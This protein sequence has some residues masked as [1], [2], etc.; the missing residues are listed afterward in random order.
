MKHCIYCTKADLFVC[1][2]YLYYSSTLLFSIQQGTYNSV[3]A[4][5]LKARQP[6]PDTLFQ[7]SSF[8]WCFMYLLFLKES[9]HGWTSR[10]Q[11]SWM[12][13]VGFSGIYL[14]DEREHTSS[15]RHYNLWRYFGPRP[16][17]TSLFIFI[18]S[19]ALLFLKRTCFYSSLFNSRHALLLD[20]QL[21]IL[22]M[23]VCPKCFCSICRVITVLLCVCLMF[24][25]AWLDDKLLIFFYLNNL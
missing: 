7:H 13:N 21:L 4:R 18:T 9:L 19:S 25:A 15:L 22:L 24:Y 16:E 5:V 20:V 14:L 10:I 23:L 2:S 6:W 17:L 1:L 3:N 8:L 12:S 11:G